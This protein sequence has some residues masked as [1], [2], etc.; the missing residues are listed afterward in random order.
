MTARPG[1]ALERFAQAFTG[2]PVADLA[3]GDV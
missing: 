2:D 3:A 1:Q